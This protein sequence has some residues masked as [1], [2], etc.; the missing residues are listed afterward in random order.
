MKRNTLLKLLDDYTPS[1]E[2][3]SYKQKMIQFAKEHQDCLERTLSL[4]HF[5]A[6]CWLLNKEGSKALLM[7]HAKLDIWCQLGGHCDGDGDILG[8]ALKEAKE[9]SGISAILPVHE[10]IFD[11]DIH[12]VPAYKQISAHLHYDIIFLLQV[13]SDEQVT[14]NQESKELRWVG[15]NKAELPTLEPSVLR[16]FNK[17]LFLRAF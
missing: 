15:K 12:L 10:Q 2:E 5:T 1:F 17:W 3:V 11:L 6:S 13:T 4:G 14:L 9:E 8:V 7:H 16:M